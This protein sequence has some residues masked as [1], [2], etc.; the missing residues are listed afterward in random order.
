MTPPR[1]VGAGRRA[2]LT[3]IAILLLGFA[4]SGPGSAAVRAAT[5]CV[6]WP[7]SFGP[8]ATIRVLRTETGIV[9]TVPFRAY[10]ENVM[11]WEWPS[12]YPLAAREVGAIV[13]KQYAWYHVTKPRSWYVTPV[14]ECYHVRDDTNDQ[15]YDPAR[16]PSAAQLAA[17][18]AT[19][20]VTL[21]KDDAFF[22]SGYGPGTQDVCGADLVST[23]TRVAQRG[24]RA[25]ALAGDSR[26]DILRTYLEPGLSIASAV[27]YFGADRF[28][29]AAEISRVT[30]GVAPATAYV[31][32]GRG[33]ADALATGA[34]AGWTESPLLLV[35][36]D[37]LPAATAAELDRLGPARIVVL[38]GPGAV[39]DAVLEALREHAPLVER[40]AGDDR[41]ATAA[42]ISEAT[43]EPGVPVAFIATGRDYPDALAGAAAGAAIGGPVLL[44][45]GDAIPPVVATELARLAPAAIRVLG[46]SAAV[47]DTV[48]EALG[49]YAA[50]VSRLAGPD[51]YAT[52]AA[53]S[54]T[55]PPDVAELFIAT[56]TDYPD[57][58]AGSPLGGPLLLVRPGA[59]GDAVVMEIARLRPG[60][61]VALGGPGVITDQ[62]IGGVVAAIPETIVVP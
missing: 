28:A 20:S 40:I 4:S 52:A 49:P 57:A 46:G 22:L 11:A 36:P 58:L 29:T 7:T 27:R 12:S 37:R 56:G 17:V 9:E 16:I 48:L 62:T 51:R 42:A 55:Y 38:G 59:L 24:V 15:I 26:D 19:W 60:R 10:V 18:A 32:T 35:E 61:V 13:V 39:G 21:R 54:A 23:R 30:S 53:I 8:P 34:A 43:F 5:G 1:P 3:T 2:A 31:A 25:C 33:F 45:P 41:Y 47:A 44:V 50:D 14:G 6:A